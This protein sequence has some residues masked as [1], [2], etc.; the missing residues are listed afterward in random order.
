MDIG[1]PWRKP[2]DKQQ[3]RVFED[4][5]DY[6]GACGITHGP[7][8]RLPISGSDGTEPHNRKPWE[9][10]N[11]ADAR[12]LSLPRGSGFQ[13]PQ[14]GL[15]ESH[16]SLNES[17]ARRGPGVSSPATP[18]SASPRLSLFPGQSSSATVRSVLDH[19]IDICLARPV[20]RSN[21]PVNNTTPPLMET[22][23]VTR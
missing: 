20:R 13:S 9:T 10:R 15:P 4:P 17:R 12:Y 18:G 1:I 11:E 21:L 8:G 16:V 23:N 19:K 7:R 5:A 14:R 2:L 6:D 22:D 3:V